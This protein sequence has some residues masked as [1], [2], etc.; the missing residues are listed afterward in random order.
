MKRGDNI[1]QRAQFCK[2]SMRDPKAA[3]DILRSMADGL[4]NCRNTTD[5]I[6]ALRAIFSVSERTIFNDL[7]SD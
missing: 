1:K 2:L 5:T 3:A 6:I 7:V 4:E